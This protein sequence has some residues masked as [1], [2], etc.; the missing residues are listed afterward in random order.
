MGWHPRTRVVSLLQSIPD[1]VVMQSTQA[2]LVYR[3][4]LKLSTAKRLWVLAPPLIE[5]HPGLPNALQLARRIATHAGARMLLA[6]TDKTRKAIESLPGKLPAAGSSKIPSLPTW[7]DVLRQFSSAVADGDALL[8]LSVRRG[9]LAWQPR[10]ERLP[11]EWAS[12]W[13]DANLLVLFPPLGPAD[14]ETERPDGQDPA[15]EAVPVL[16]KPLAVP[17]RSPRLPEALRELVL[18]ALPE[19]G[20]QPETVVDG[21]LRTG[22]APLAE[23][24]VLLHVTTP[25]VESPRIAVGCRPDGFEIDGI[26]KTPVELVVLFSPRSGT[27]ERHL[28]TLAAIARAASGGTLVPRS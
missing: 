20:G 27:P 14:A 22:P 7:N 12:R 8:L 6:A 21:L 4:G 5:H 10:L 11:I 25:L 23:K 18:A 26:E 16:P 24:I 19:S 9:N 1:R 2:V 28:Q 15:P 17:I 3:S 13:P